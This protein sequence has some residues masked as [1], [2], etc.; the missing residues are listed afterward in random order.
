MTPSAALDTPAP[1]GLYLPCRFLALGVIAVN[2]A[3]LFVLLICALFNN[4]QTQ[5]RPASASDAS[6]R[7]FLSQWERAQSRFINGDPTLWKQNASHND[8]ATILG[9]FGGYGEKGWG[10]VGARYDWASSQYKSGG[11][12][13]H[14]EYINIVVSGDLAFTVGIERQEGARVGDQQSPTRRAL[15]ATQ[16][17]RR[18]DGVWKLLHRHADPLVEKLPPESRN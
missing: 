11:A 3:F 9:A 14:V 6:F 5:G 18:E 8:D 7:A 2:K 1:A 15:R 13:V 12:T 4:A 10:A 17:F 16:I